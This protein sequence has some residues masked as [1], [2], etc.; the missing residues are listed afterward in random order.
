MKRINFVEYFPVFAVGILVKQISNGSEHSNVEN[1]VSHVKPGACSVYLLDLDV[2]DDLVF[3]ADC[4][5]LLYDVD[6]LGKELDDGA[7]G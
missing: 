2:L 4:Y 1:L 5:R 6:Y 3:A 7:D